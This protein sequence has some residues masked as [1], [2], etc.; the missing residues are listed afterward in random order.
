MTP[1]RVHTAECAQKNS[2]STC[3]LSFFQL[4]K[5]VKYLTEESGSVDKRVEVE[6]AFQCSDMSKNQEKCALQTLPHMCTT[7]ADINH[8]YIEEIHINQVRHKDIS[9]LKC[10]E[11]DYQL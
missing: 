4:A 1:H 8:K 10:I 11:Y 6:Q 9:Q 2:V 5:W 7:T 3:K